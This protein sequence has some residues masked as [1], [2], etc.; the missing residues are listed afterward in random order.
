MLRKIAK[1]E[2]MPE[3][4]VYLAM[5][6]SGLNPNAVSWAKAVGMWQFIASTGEMYDLDITTWVDERRD[7]EKATAALSAAGFGLVT[8]AKAEAM[9]GK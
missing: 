5:M 1:E 8:D 3:E 6:E 9:E 2:D 7:V 4:I